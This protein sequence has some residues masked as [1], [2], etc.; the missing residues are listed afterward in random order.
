MI[1]HSCKKEIIFRNDSGILDAASNG[2]LA[3][4]PVILGIIANIIAFISFV[5]FVNGILFWLGQLLGYDDWK[6]QVMKKYSFYFF[7]F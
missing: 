7:L 6:F 5:A 3:A 1:D 4:I 2:A